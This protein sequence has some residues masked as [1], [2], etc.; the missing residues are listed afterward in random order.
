M[1][2]RRIG[3]KTERTAAVAAATPNQSR[4]MIAVARPPNSVIGGARRMQSFARQGR[5]AMRRYG[6][7]IETAGMIVSRTVNYKNHTDH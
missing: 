1:L 6:A 3:V 7:R 4:V 5:W 2:E